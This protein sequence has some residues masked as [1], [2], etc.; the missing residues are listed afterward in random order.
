MPDPRYAEEALDLLRERGHRITRPRRLVVSVLA[1]QDRPLSPYDIHDMLVERSEKIDTVTIYRILD[2]LES[3][4]LAHR[5][6]HT[7]GFLRCRFQEHDACHHHVI[8]RDCG[9]IE[10]IHCPGMNAVE[11][12]AATESRYRIDAH[13]VEFLGLCAACQ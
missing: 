11:R 1:Q 9:A 3:Y 12:A 6:A 5:L 2:R 13:Y 10:E 7:G 8:C 4:G